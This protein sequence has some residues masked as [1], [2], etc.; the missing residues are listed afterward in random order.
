M[1]NFSGINNFVGNSNESIMRFTPR[2]LIKYHMEHPEIPITDDDIANLILDVPIVR[3][4]RSTHQ[5]SVRS[6]AN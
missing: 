4:L 6:K 2:Q 5:L 1:K 3:D